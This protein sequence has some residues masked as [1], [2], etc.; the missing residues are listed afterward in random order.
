MIG[1]TKN[2]FKLVMIGSRVLLTKSSWKVD[3]VVKIKGVA[4][5]RS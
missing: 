3:N 2:P 1:G 4:K 5:A